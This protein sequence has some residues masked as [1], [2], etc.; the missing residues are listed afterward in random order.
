[1][2]FSN[3]AVRKEISSAIFPVYEQVLIAEVGRIAAVVPTE[4][5]AIQ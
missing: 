3:L 5:L 4:E 2:A 1:M